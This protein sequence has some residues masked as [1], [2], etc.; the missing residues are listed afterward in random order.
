MRKLIFPISVYFKKGP[1][2]KNAWIIR[3][4]KEDR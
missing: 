1:F 2:G 3:G 4:Q